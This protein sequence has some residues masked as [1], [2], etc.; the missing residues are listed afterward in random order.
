MQEQN[1]I[2]PNVPGATTGPK[3]L[4]T[5]DLLGETFGIFKRRWKLLVL[6]Q[7]IPAILSLI[8]GVI[9][10]L[11][12][13]DREEISWPLVIVIG[14]LGILILVVSIWAMCALMLAVARHDETGKNWKDYFREGIKIFWGVLGV[15]ILVGLA[16]LGGFILLII[17]GFIFAIWFGF[18]VWVYIEAGKGSGLVKALRESKRIVKG[19]FWS[20]VWRNLG[21][22]VL[23]GLAAMVAYVILAI[24]VAL[25]GLAFAGNETVSALIANVLSVPI[26]V[27]LT[28]ISLVFAY[29]LY[30]NIR[31]LKSVD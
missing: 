22:G 28:P 4:G 20:I 9:D 24:L 1:A 14:V 10:P 25:I 7:I 12:Q 27:V 23:I 13:S 5:F 31:E 21:F 26:Q 17:P 30:R 2:Q 11:T 29:L 19:Y 3:L 6:I 8:L 18:A 16:T 15:W